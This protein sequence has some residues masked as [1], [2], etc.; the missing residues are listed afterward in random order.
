[1]SRRLYSNI[2]AFGMSLASL[3]EYAEA[4]P[5]IYLVSQQEQEAPQP[6]RLPEITIMQTLGLSN[7]KEI[8]YLP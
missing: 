1:M 8:A 4:N 5:G 2:L 3:A 7:R 6:S